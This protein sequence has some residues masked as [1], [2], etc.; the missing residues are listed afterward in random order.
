MCSIANHVQISSFAG[1]TYLVAKPCTQE[2]SQSQHTMEL[3]IRLTGIHMGMSHLL[4]TLQLL[5]NLHV[6]ALIDDRLPRS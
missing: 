6:S 4:V 1:K 5:L 3:G 2:N